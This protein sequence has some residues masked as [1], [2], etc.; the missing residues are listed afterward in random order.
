MDNNIKLENP[1][2][3]KYSIVYADPPWSYSCWS[4]KT[5]RTADSHYNVMTLDDIKALPIADITADNAVL[6]M[7]ITM[8]LLAQSFEVM[9]S[10]GFIYKTNAF[11]WVK[12]N[13]KN[14]DTWFWGNGHYTRANAEL[15]LLASKGKGLPRLSRSVH[16]VIDTPIERHS[17]KP[18]IVRDR[19][20]E[21]YG[22]VPRIELFTRQKVNG[23]TCLGNEIDGRDIR[24]AMADIVSALNR[25][26][27]LAA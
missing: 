1:A 11:T 9:K 24:D 13:K 22:N 7:W 5:T 23:W 12:R 27:K 3:P 4:K 20:V 6:F 26:K 2:K 18:D 14:T 16:S 15:C 17:K 19:I 21:L 25:Q 8:P 10:W